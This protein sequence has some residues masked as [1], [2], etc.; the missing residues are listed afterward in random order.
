MTLRKLAVLLVLPLAIG[1][2]TTHDFPPSADIRAVT[3]TKP[4]PPASILTDTTASDRYNAQLEAWGERV[5]AAG[6]RLCRYF[7]TEGMKVDCPEAEAK[8]Q[9]KILPPEEPRQ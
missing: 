5:R 8:M 2:K 9:E 3:E 4:L 7:K 1:C 6:V